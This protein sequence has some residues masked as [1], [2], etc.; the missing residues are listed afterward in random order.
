MA[1]GLKSTIEFLTQTEANLYAICA[2]T[3]PDSDLEKDIKD[4]FD[5]FDD[6]DTVVIMTDILSGS[7]NQK[8]HPYLSERVHLIAGINAPLAMQLVLTEEEDM[9][10]ETIAECIDMAK[11]TVVYINTMS[12]DDD[13]DDE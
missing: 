4:L 8:F 11:D 2:Y 5:T 6:N 3:T 7:V 12:S 13:E 9:T 1:E 10:A